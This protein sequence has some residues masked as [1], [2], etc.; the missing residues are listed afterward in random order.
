MIKWLLKWLK[1]LRRK[2]YAG[3]FVENILKNKKT[4]KKNLL[5]FKKICDET[6]QNVIKASIRLVKK[7]TQRKVITVITIIFI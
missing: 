3:S 2:K 1:S 5:V 7:Y 6:L 4:I